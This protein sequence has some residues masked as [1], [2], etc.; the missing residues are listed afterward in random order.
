MSG[1][2]DQ[3]AES[4]LK[5]WGPK[6]VPGCFNILMIHQT[7]SGF[8]PAPNT[9]DTA[10]LPQGFDLIVSGHFH[11]AQEKGNILIPGSL[12][13][14]QLDKDS[15]RPRGFFK[16]HVA[17]KGYSAEFMQLERQRPVYYRE[18][19][20]G[21][22]AAQREI[23]SILSRQHSIKPVIRVKVSEKNGHD[24]TKELARQY[25]GRA[26]LSFRRDF[27]SEAIESRTIE[28]QRLSVRELGQKLL[29]QNL[30]QAGLDP[31]LY[32]AVFDL[33]LNRKAEEA[34]KLIRDKT[35]N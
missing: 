14:T 32:E 4:V 31:E 3:Y 5:E 15:G 20:G 11:D 19:E 17:G 16:V 21:K 1:V 26:V 28:E 6:P 18:V 35:K 25:E 30:G 34:L 7:L 10:R 2:P 23:E 22:E 33:L 29:K 9:L 13:Q 8:I 24:Y 12:V 27:S